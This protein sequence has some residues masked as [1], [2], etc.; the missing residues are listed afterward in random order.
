MITIV[1][2]FDYTHLT[3]LR[4]VTVTLR[5]VTTHRCTSCGEN[6]TF[7]E[8]RRIADLEQELA[9]AKALHVKQLWCSFHDNQW[10]VAFAPVLPK[11]PTPRRRK[12]H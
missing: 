10:T 12:S 5:D 2:D 9:A 11:A 3:D 6:S 4:G 7:V 1:D 8:I